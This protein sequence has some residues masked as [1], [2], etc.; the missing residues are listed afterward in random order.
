MDSK[1]YAEEFGDRFSEQIGRCFNAC[2]KVIQYFEDDGDDKDYYMAEL[3]GIDEALEEGKITWE[4]TLAEKVDLHKNHIYGS[5]I[6]M[7]AALIVIKKLEKEMDE[8]KE[9]EKKEDV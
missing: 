5:I 1:K 6:D 9:E 2:E 8:E 4:E 3:E 7:K